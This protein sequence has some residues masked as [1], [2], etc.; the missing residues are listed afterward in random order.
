[1]AGPLFTD[2]APAV[3][4]AP[5]IDALRRGSVAARKAGQG[6]GPGEPGRAAAGGKGPARR[7]D[8]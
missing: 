7:S 8:E 2:F 3:T 4:L 1:V 5:H 6:R